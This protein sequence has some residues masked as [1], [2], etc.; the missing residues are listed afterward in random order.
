MGKLFYVDDE[1]HFWDMNK[2]SYKLEDD[3]HHYVMKNPRLVSRAWGDGT[4]DTLYLIRH[5]Q[6]VILDSDKN[7][8][9]L[10][11]LL[12]D[13]EGVPVLV[14]AKKS[15][16]RE[17]RR[18]VAAQ[19]IDYA[20]RAHGWNVEDLRKSFE[21][22]NPDKKDEMDDAFW[23]TVADN[24]LKEHFRLV[25]IAEE[26]PPE[27]QTIIEFMDR[28][29]QGIEVYGVELQ[30]YTTRERRLIFSSNVIGNSPDES[31]KPTAKRTARVWS[32]ADFSRFLNDNGLA[33]LDETINE[34]RWEAKKAGY[35]IVGGTG[36][37]GPSF[38]AK[39]NGQ[40]VFLV[41]V[42]KKAG[43]Y[44]ASFDFAPSQLAIYLGN[45]WSD[46]SIRSYLNEME[47]FKEIEAKGFRSGGST[48][49]YLDIKAFK[50][51]KAFNE[52]SRQITL[53]NN[54]IRASA[55]KPVKTE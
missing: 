23:A 9:S 13:S 46:E 37:N 47:L 22:C 38:L 6:P 24:L 11:V 44:K 49:I 26:I 1:E 20:A 34:I 17:L 51:Q 2:T 16:N 15:S 39:C 5:E 12:V 32:D 50:D 55:D 29:M 36:S 52:L 21:D 33:D 7:E 3:L 48:W 42:Y 28:V 14:E 27:M 4:E 40:T 30:P 31:S 8:L 45:E 18:S 10:D 19:M 35:D 25:F 53:L 54:A 41:S 43:K